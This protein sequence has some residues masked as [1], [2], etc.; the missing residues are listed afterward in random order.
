MNFSTSYELNQHIANSSCKE[1]QDK[2]FR[3]YICNRIFSMG[4]AKKKHIQED[5]Q[6]KAGQDCPLCLRCKIPSAVSY[7]NHYKTHFIPPRFSCNFCERNFYESDRLQMHIRR[8]HDASSRY[9][10]FFC[11]KKFRDKSGIARHIQGVHFNDRK[12]KCAQCSKAFT[13][14]YNL[15]EH[16]FSIHKQASTVYTC[17]TCCQE[18]LYRKQFERHRKQCAG[19][20]EKRKR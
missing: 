13:T 9:T 16:M 12:Y 15:K 10:C 3:C 8:N 11:S 2:S 14:S 17:E 1:N 4:I 20:P 18:Y 6:D 19:F 7:E 5:H